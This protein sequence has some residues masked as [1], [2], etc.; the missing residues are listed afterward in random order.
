VRLKFLKQFGKFES[1]SSVYTAADFSVQDEQHSAQ[2]A[3]RLERNAIPPSP[4]NTLN[5]DDAPF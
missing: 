2:A 3:E 5:P 1:L 4:P